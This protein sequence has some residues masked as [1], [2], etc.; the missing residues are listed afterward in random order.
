MKR[1]SQ[2]YI[3][4][5]R[6]KPGGSNVG[7]YS[8]NQTFAGPDG[9]S[10]EGSFPIGTLQHGKSALKLAYNAPNPG[11]IKSAVYRK[12][13]QLRKMSG[14]GNIWNNEASQ[15]DGNWWSGGVSSIVS[16]IPVVGD[17]LGGIIDIV[18]GYSSKVDEENRNKALGFK[19][20][21]AKESNMTPSRNPYA[22]TYMA[23]MGGEVPSANVEVE[24]NEVAMTPD[25]ENA[26]TFE[27]PT[28][29]QGGIDTTLPVG[30]EVF[31]DD[32]KV[33]ST[34]YKGQ[35]YAQVA[36]KKLAYVES[37]KK[38]YDKNPSLENKNTYDLV[39]KRTQEELKALFA[40][41]EQ[42]KQSQEQLDMLGAPEEMSGMSQEQPLTQEGEEGYASG[43]KIPRWLYA[44]RGRAMRNKMQGGGDV[45]PLTGSNLPYPNKLRD[46]NLP[47][48]SVTNPYINMGE[49]YDII[50]SSDFK[51]YFDP[52]RKI[53]NVEPAPADEL[54]PEYFQPKERRINRYLRPVQPAYIKGEGDIYK[55]GSIINDYLVGSTYNVDDNEVKR[56][57]G[58]GYKIQRV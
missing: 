56:L 15:D 41:Q 22:P 35:T 24:D 19:Q 34:Q 45:P 49:E 27:G 21:L 53:P 31:S 57:I 9:G 55:F 18:G 16:A 54:Y 2:T 13:P 30:S 29:E 10:P 28:H 7:K 40:H 5:A 36:Q 37:L 47:Y 44:A 3:R 12:Y 42:T 50:N 43:G 33:D 25:G 52:G 48:N 58:L 23:A 39:S 11:G 32:I 26:V 38:A 6:K 4:N 51:D 1:L 17:V 8:P 14:G 20:R 46:D